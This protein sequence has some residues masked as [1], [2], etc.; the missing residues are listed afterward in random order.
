MCNFFFFSKLSSQ[1][2]QITNKFD[3]IN[4]IGDLNIDTS[5]KV[6][7]TLN[8]LPLPDLCDTSL[9]NITRKSSFKT[10]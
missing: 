4:V 10:K 9:T 2:N 6:K 5:N 7:D 8:C 3:D 1:L